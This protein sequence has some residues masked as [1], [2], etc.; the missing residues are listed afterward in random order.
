MAQLRL[1]AAQFK[2]SLSAQSRCQGGDL[3]RLGVK[4]VVICEATSGTA[5]D[6]HT[7]GRT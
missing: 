1:L 2:P 7:M 4:L 3:A 5:T 6:G